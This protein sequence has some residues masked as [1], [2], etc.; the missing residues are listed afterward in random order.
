MLLELFGVYYYTTAR[1][2][3]NTLTGVCWDAS[4]LH[5]KNVILTANLEDIGLES[6]SGPE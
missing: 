4:K 5:N 2:Q 6:D 3:M 1:F